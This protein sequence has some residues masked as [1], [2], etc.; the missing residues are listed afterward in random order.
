MKNFWQCCSCKCFCSKFDGI[1]FGGQVDFMRGA[2]IGK[3]GLGKPIIALPSQTEKGVSKIVNLLKP[4]KTANVSTSMYNLQAAETLADFFL[5][6]TRFV[7][8]EKNLKIL[9]WNKMIPLQV[10]TEK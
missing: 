9:F 3:D 7:Y 1:G 2:A 10:Q 5:H 4:G 6:S 8:Y